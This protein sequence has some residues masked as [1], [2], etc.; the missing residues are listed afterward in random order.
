MLFIS[1]NATDQ[2]QC[3]P[4]K[5][6]LYYMADFSFLARYKKHI[7]QL[8]LKLGWCC[9]TEF[10]H[11]MWAEVRYIISNPGI[12]TPGETLLTFYQV[13]MWKDEEAQTADPML[14]AQL[15]RPHLIIL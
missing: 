14:G 12:K 8:P 15:P 10:G 1:F 9:M 6:A 5:I 13:G 7:V 3:P 4:K 11:G 2:T